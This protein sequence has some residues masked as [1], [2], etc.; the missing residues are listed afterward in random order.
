M[1]AYITQGRPDRGLIRLTP[2]AQA[3]ITR[4]IGVYAAPL[5]QPTQFTARTTQG[6]PVY[7]YHPTAIARL[8][9]PSN[10]NI[11]YFTEASD[12]QQR[13]P[14]VGCAPV[15]ITWHADG[16]NVEHHTGTTIVGASS[17]GELRTLAG[18]V[19]GR[20]PPTRIWPCNIWVVVDATVHIHLTRRLADL[21]P[22][23]ALGS[24]PT[25]QSLGLGMAF[26]GMHPQDA[27]P[28][29]QTGVTPLRIRQW[30]RRH[31]GQTPEHQSHPRA[32]TRK[33][34]HPTP[35]PPAAPAPETVG[36]T[37]PPLDTRG[38]A[39]HRS[40]SST[41]TPHPSSSWPPHW[42]TQ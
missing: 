24:G 37:A 27:L 28:H 41:A 39:V 1:Y 32:R 17:H 8:P 3:I 26:R 10:T 14:T 5:L 22:H 4:G 13:T 34:G 6:N 35:Q 19:T 11:I 31:A 42:A 40:A 23:K 38:H 15:R 36:R 21:P 7:S 25:S 33:T 12:T 2:P 18:D 20:P 9:I 30:T 29:R 16:L